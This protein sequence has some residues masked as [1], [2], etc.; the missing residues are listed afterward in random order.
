MKI[1]KYLK[2]E[3][4]DVFNVHLYNLHIYSS[5][6][7]KMHFILNIIRCLRKTLQEFVK[8]DCHVNLN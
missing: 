6:N 4:S 5:K 1:K 8:L 7:L 2:N 3:R